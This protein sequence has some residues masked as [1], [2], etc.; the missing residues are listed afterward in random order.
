MP[1]TTVELHQPNSGLWLPLKRTEDGFWTMGSGAFERPIRLPFR[2]RL[3]SPV[4]Q[5][6]EDTI[7]SLGKYIDRCGHGKISK[8]KKRE[9]K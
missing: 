7:W 3:H 4:G 9:K 6:L 5:M 2:I 8:R 1:A